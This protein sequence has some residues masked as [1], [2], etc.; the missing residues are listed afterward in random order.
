MGR[1]PAGGEEAADPGR[2]GARRGGARAGRRREERRGGAG[3]ARGKEGRGRRREAVR[4]SGGRER[5][6]E[7][8]RVR[9]CGGRQVRVSTSSFFY[10]SCA[11]IFL[12]VHTFFSV[13]F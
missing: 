4:G 3:A 8:A 1:P 12:C 9:A 7:Q 5:R 13:R 6:A 11:Y 2:R 10:L